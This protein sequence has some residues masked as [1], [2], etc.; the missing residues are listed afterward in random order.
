M[1]FPPTGARGRPS[2]TWDS[3]GGRIRVGL[4]RM[5]G[6]FFLRPWW[7][8]GPEA[9]LDRSSTQHPR[10]MHTNS[11]HL[12]SMTQRSERLSGRSL[13]RW[14]HQVSHHGRV[15]GRGLEARCA[16]IK[17]TEETPVFQ[18][19]YVSGETHPDEKVH[20]VLNAIDN[21]YHRVIF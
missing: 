14:R 18:I 4:R 6:L 13:Q 3:R 21:V 17:E 7:R 16:R 19:D 11:L 2:I 1:E 5:F 9:R 15:A 8:Q 12:E 20:P 10:R